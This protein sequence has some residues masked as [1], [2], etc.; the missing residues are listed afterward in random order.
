MRLSRPDSVD[1]AKRRHFEISIDS[2]FHI[3]SC[4][5]SQANTALPAYCSPESADGNTQVAECGCPGAP[6]RRISPNRVPTLNSL[7]ESRQSSNSGASDAS[8]G[9]SAAAGAQERTGAPAY[10]G[11]PSNVASALA[12]SAF[13]SARSPGVA[14]N[15]QAPLTRPQ[16]AHIHTNSPALQRPMHMLRTP[17]FNPPAFEDE[18][19]PPPLAT[20]PPQYADIAS[21][22]RGLSD[23][24]SRLADAY[25]DVD[26]DEEDESRG[27]RR[28]RVRV[29]LT[30]GSRVNRSMEIVRGSGWPWGDGEPILDGNNP[31]G[32]ETHLQPPHEALG[33]GEPS[34]LDATAR[35]TTP[36]NSVISTAPAPLHEP[37]AAESPAQR[38][39]TIRLVDP[40]SPGEEI[41]SMT[42]GRT[43][44]RAGTGTSSQM[45]SSPRDIVEHMVRAQVE[46]RDSEREGAGAGGGVVSSW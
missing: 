43:R 29:P 30:P 44:E 33:A 41:P 40:E 4:R 46:R 39:S 24:F 3:L 7:N 22:T 18:Q 5:A 14:G 21:P 6:L 26:T 10:R 11:V 42:E 25:D 9:S 35:S 38:Q 16:P 12:A 31:R 36:R 8:Q 37:T 28:G 13:A 1:P 45:S 17:S 15:A 34:A 23:Y 32:D 27:H 19:P 2:P 20:P